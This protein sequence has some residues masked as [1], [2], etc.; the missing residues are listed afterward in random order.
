MFNCLDPDAK[1]CYDSDS[2]RREA[3]EVSD[4]QLVGTGPEGLLGQPLTL[5]GG[6]T[7]AL[8]VPRVV[9][10]GTKGEELGELHDGHGVLHV[11]LIM[12]KMRME[13]SRRACGRQ[14]QS[15]CQG[16]ASFSLPHEPLSSLAFPARQPH[17]QWGKYARPCPAV[18]A[19]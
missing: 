13:A 15:A 11:L 16:P 19:A 9:F 8:Y 1:G 10:D 7:A 18:T 5:P 14:P 4:A 2:D 6:G 17:A 3:R 12:A